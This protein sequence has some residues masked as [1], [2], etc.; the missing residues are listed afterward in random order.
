MVY[1]ANTNPQTTVHIHHA[2]IELHL[3]RSQ[4]TVLPAGEGGEGGEEKTNQKKYGTFTPTTTVLVNLDAHYDG[5]VQTDASVTG[6]AGGS[7][8]CDGDST[9]VDAVGADSEKGRESMQLEPGGK[10][11]F[12]VRIEPRRGGGN[13]STAGGGGGRGGRGGGGGGG[14]SERSGSG[15]GGVGGGIPDGATIL[16]TPITITWSSDA[17]FTPITLR[18][19]VTWPL[20]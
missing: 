20:T 3:A 1:V 18:A 12:L 11:A 4:V 15:E 14:G 9:G 8:D 17:T 16:R 2:D 19:W 6:R 13:G 5:Y 7:A 10:L